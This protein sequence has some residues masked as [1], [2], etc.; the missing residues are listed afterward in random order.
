M[1]INLIPKLGDPDSTNP[2]GPCSGVDGGTDESMSQQFGI[3][4]KLADPDSCCV[5]PSET[6]NCRN[7][8]KYNGISA[9]CSR[10]DDGAHESTSPQ[11]SITPKSGQI[12]DL[13]RC[14]LCADFVAEVADESRKLRRR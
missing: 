7:V 14:P 6:S 8:R 12:A 9:P 13:S 5:R 2:G 11:A 4:P 3:I 10:A 1:L